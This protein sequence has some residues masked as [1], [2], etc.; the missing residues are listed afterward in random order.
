MNPMLRLVD[1]A[2]ELAGRMRVDSIMDGTRSALSEWVSSR[3]WLSRPQR[4]NR[5]SRVGLY[6][7]I[8]W[9]PPRDAL[10]D[11]WETTA[12]DLHD[13]TAALDTALSTEP[14]LLQA[15]ASARQ[16]GG[17]WLWPVT[18]DQN[19]S[20][21]LPNTA[22][23][24][25]ALHVLTRDEVSV[26]DLEHD[27]RSKNWS[28]PSVVD[29]HANRNGMSWNGAAVHTSRLIYVSGAPST[30]SQQVP[31]RGY[32]LPVLELYRQAIDDY[33]AAVRN[34]GRLI[35]R[36]SMPWIRLVS[37]K[38]AA[39]SGGNDYEARL[40]LLRMSMGDA[41]GL[42]VLLGDDEAGWSGPSLG[43]VRDAVNILA[44]RVSSIEGFPLSRLIGQAPGGLSTDDASG[45]R[46]YNAFLSHERRL[47][48]TP[49]LLR[50]YDIALGPDPS[51][52]VIWPVLDSP[53]ILE[54]AQASEA[55]ARRDAVLVDL[56]AIGPDESRGRFVDGEE[57]ALPVIDTEDDDV[58]EE[59]GGTPLDDSE[60]ALTDLAPGEKASDKL[61]NG[62]QIASAL[63]IVDRVATR[64]LPRESG[65]ESLQSFFGMTVEQAEKV[66]GAVGKTFFI[67]TPDE[68]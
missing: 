51:R 50:L 67:D 62:A 6:H 43:G 42:M 19:W 52:K 60:A 23:E 28:K 16:D 56:G 20:E 7:R 35:N 63:E 30:P 36:L 10:G 17:A 49:P 38:D 29:V 15:R 8:C 24:V 66:M 4:E 48:L 40:E 9:G 21:P 37:A 11:G 46:S 45:K 41:L 25:V 59:T 44:E 53:T 64:K 13:V 26:R 2:R 39:A 34:V 68:P 12:G 57:S 55:N 3:S 58:V 5:T 22:T 18:A 33:D 32:D 65:I 1:G 61:P 47:V 31:E 54:T 14:A 27:P